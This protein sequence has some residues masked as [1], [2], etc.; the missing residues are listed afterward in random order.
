[1]KKNCTLLLLIFCS[2]VTHAEML[3]IDIYDEAQLDS[4]IEQN[5][6]LQQITDDDCQLVQDIEARAE[7]LR[8]PLYQFLW[9]EML[10][11]GVCVKADPG[12]GITQLKDS[13]KQ[14]NS[15]AMLVLAKLYLSSSFVVANPNLAYRYIYTAAEIGNQA[16]RLE[17]VRQQ[18]KYSHHASDYQLAYHWLYNEIFTEP[19]TKEAAQTLLKLLAAKMPRSILQQA[20]QPMTT[21]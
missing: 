11:Y 16:A 13:A 6:H 18:L 4:F 21:D 5:N 9:G 3:A 12:R 8:Q 19:T 17:L 7:R 15:H 10:L 14:G 1:M 2:V 20:R